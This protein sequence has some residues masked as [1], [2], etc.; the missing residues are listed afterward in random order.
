[1]ALFIEGFPLATVSRVGTLQGENPGDDLSSNL[2]LAKGKL[3]DMGYSSPL[4]A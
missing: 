2:P 3:L 1:M 4:T